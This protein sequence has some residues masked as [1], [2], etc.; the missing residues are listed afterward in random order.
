[1]PAAGQRWVTLGELRAAHRGDVRELEQDLFGIGATPGFAIGQRA[2]LVRTP[3]GNVLW[4]CIPLLD[5]E[6]AERVRGLGGLAAIAISHPHFYTSMVEWSHAFG[7]VPVYLHA[8]DRQWVMRPDPVIEHWEGETRQILPGLTLVR[9][10]GH[11]PGSSVL[12]WE[13]GA[14]LTG[15]TIMVAADR[16]HVSFMYS[17]P[18]LIPLAAAEVRRLAAA[19]RPYA[20]DRIY[21]GWWDRVIPSEARAAVEARSSATSPTDSGRRARPAAFA[22]IT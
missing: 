20:Y 9:C 7:R 3:A 12:H 14:L 1:M 21:G 22:S 5:D 13:R 6:I 11:F 2:L 17:Y 15:D 10:G 19:V 16:R 18:N 4:D 8:D